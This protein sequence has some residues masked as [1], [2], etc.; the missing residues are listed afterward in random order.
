[1]RAPAE[2]GPLDEPA[3]LA[4]V[5]G[6]AKLA[7]EIA[8]LFLADAP[9]SLARLGR[10]MEAG[11]LAAASQAAHALKGALSHLGAEP[12]RRAALELETAAAAG[13]P[14]PVRKALAALERE[15][16][17]LL[18]ELRALRSRLRGAARR[19]RRA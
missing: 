13:A 12:A 7:S 19:R 2:P 16:E 10:A 3:L 8:G 14:A 18:P 15:V 17:L 1:V 6:D 9:R 11:D 4:Q 5:Q